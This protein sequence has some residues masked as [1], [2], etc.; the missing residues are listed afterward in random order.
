VAS[1]DEAG[2]AENGSG[3][4]DQLRAAYEQRG[5]SF[6]VEPGSQTLPDFLGSYRP[7]AIAQKEGENVLI[8]IIRR[9]RSPWEQPLADV[10]GRI[11]GHKGWKL[12]IVY[13]MER[14]EDLIVIPIPRLDTLKQQIAE[15]EA[16]EAGGHHRAAFV[17]SWSVL[18]A[19]LNRVKES[20]PHRIR[21]AGQVVHTLTMDGHISA[22]T[23][24]K[25]RELSDLRNRIV[26]GDFDADASGEDVEQVL[27][28]INEALVEETQ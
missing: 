22:A 7:D 23:D 24:R 4:L 1:L 21:T 10:R 2:N 19:V 8:E 9:Q 5:F 16:L 28:A 3:I 18:E 20:G 14:P 6:V 17:L 13:A 26:H 27:A 12:N 11:A 25:L 15:V